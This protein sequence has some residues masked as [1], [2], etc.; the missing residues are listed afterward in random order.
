[1]P[2]SGPVCEQTGP[3]P[4]GRR[5]TRIIRE[6]KTMHLLLVGGNRE[7]AFNVDS[8]VGPGCPNKI[9]DVLLVQ[10]FLQQMAGLLIT[11]DEDRKR[12]FLKVTTSGVCDDATIDGIIAAQEMFRDQGPP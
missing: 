8:P 9:E 3:P 4:R 10:F 7:V 5:W 1:M 2:P 12:R 6:D 11:T